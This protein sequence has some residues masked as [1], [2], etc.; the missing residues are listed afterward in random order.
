MQKKLRKQRAE[1]VLKAQ[2]ERDRAQQI[3]SQ[4]SSSITSGRSGEFCLKTNTE[5]NGRELTRK[6]NCCIPF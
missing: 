2:K 5:E 6:Y 4:E 3:N 1:Y